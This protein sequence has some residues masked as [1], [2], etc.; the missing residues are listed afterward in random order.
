MRQSPPPQAQ[1]NYIIVLANQG[2]AK[3]WA[4]YVLRATMNWSTHRPD[5]FLALC[6][7]LGCE[8][9]GEGSKR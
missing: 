9:A 8:A 2:V 5:T 6:D 1:R 4:E 7:Q 3:V